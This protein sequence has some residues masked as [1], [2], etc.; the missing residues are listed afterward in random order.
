M[1]PEFELIERIRATFYPEGGG[2][3]KGV[4]VAIGDDCAVF[5]PGA[6]DLITSDTMVEEVHFRRAWSA[7]EDIGFK[8]LAVSLSDVAAMGGRCGAFLLNLSFPPEIERSFVDGLIRGLK[9]AS[10]RFSSPGQP[11]LPIGGDVTGAQ[12]HISITTTVLGKAPQ[13]GALLRSGAQPGDRIMLVGSTGLAQAGLELFQGDH[14]RGEGSEGSDFQTLRRAHRRPRP[15]VLAGALIGESG[16]A[17]AM[18]DT[19]DGLL[20]DLG[21]IL[22]ASGAGARLRADRV[23]VEPELRRYCAQLATEQSEK[24]NIYHYLFAGGEDFQLCFTL[25]RADVE[26][27]ERY[28]GEQLA[29]RELGI[30]GLEL[31]DIGEVR[32]LEEGINIFDEAGNKVQIATPGF[33]HFV[34]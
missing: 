11:I 4:A 12:A 19:S 14:R 29:Q 10:E 16:L 3:P 6:F 24:E 18:I 26:R 31:V 9:A 25:P 15:Q 28:I 30:S 5:K 34:S 20:Q 32:P 22:A 13:A 2:D 21:H 33:E 7:P 23:P 8:A 1:Y 17:S 27:L